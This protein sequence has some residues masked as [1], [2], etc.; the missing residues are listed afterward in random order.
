MIVWG[1][2]PGRY[3][4]Y[5][6][7]CD[8][9]LIESCTYD[10]DP[11]AHGDARRWSSVVDFLETR[12][13]ATGMPDAIGMENA[14][15]AC[16]YGPRLQ[17]KQVQA[18]FGYMTSVEMWAVRYGVTCTVYSPATLKKRVA[19]SGRAQKRDVAAAVLELYGR[20]V[21]THDE[22]DAIAAAHCAWEELQ[23]AG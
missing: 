17:P 1:I 11:G 20:E 18:A 8:G 2:D 13:E 15:F 14:G 9:T 10:M 7:I 23:R 3:F 5:G 21:S 6:E 12:L 16:L 19:G 22:S 4:G